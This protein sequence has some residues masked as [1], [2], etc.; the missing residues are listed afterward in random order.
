MGELMGPLTVKE[1]KYGNGQ[2]RLAQHNLLTRRATEV[3][4]KLTT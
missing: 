3:F 1:D 4:K 2:E